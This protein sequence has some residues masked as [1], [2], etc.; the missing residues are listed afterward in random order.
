MIMLVNKQK[1]LVQY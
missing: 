1:G